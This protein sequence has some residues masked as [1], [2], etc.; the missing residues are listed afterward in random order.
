[1]SSATELDGMFQAGIAA[2]Q[3]GDYAQAVVLLSKLSRCER[4]AYRMQANMGLV[5]A[6]MAQQ[7]WQEAEALCQTIGTSA[8]PA[9]K[10]WS[11]TTLEKIEQRRARPKRL[12]SGFSPLAAPRNSSA[13]AAKPS[14]GF[15][16]LDPAPSDHSDQAQSSLQP[17]AHQ[18]DV[19]SRM[20]NSSGAFV[21][22]AKSTV[23]KSKTSRRR[24][25]SSPEEVADSPDS[26]TEKGPDEGT[27]LSMFHYAYLN[28]ET[29]AAALRGGETDEKTASKAAAGYLWTYAGRLQKGRSL[30]KMK[31]GKLWFAQG[32]S[33][34][35]FYLLL[36]SLIHSSL[37]LLNGY[38]H[39]LDN[40]FP[41][42]VRSLPSS[43][44]DVTW[45]LLFGLGLLT[46]AAPWLWD[47]W[48]LLTADRKPLSAS[49]LRA[50]SAE[51]AAL[52]HGYC[53]QR[54]FSFPTLWTLKTDIPLIFSYGWRPK[55]ARLVI[56]QGLL[57]QLKKDE[58]AALVAY[59]LSHWKGWHW[60]LL[61]AQGLILQVLLEGYWQLSVWGNR[62]PSKL[63][64]YT[65]GGLAMVSYAVF[66][67]LGIPSRW[68]SR[69]R[70][71]YSDRMAAELTGNPNGLTRGLTNL[72]FGLAA[73]VEQ[74]TYTP[75][76]VESLMPLLPAV[77][78][79]ARQPLFGHLPLS[80]LFAWDS[81]QPLRLW[82]S[83]AETHPP[84]GDRLR[85]LMA[86]AKHWR[87]DLEIP[88]LPASRQ[89]QKM[90][91]QD[92]QVLLQQG[93]P[94][95][96]L[97]FGLLIGLGLWGTGLVAIWLQWPALDWMYQDMGLLQCCCLLGTSV[98]I[99][100]RI[101]RF[102]PDLD[103]AMPASQ[104]VPDWVSRPD[105]LPAD[106]LPAKL[107]GV[108]VG[109]PGIANWLGQDLLL[110]TSFGLVKLHYFSLLGPLGNVLS[111]EQTPALVQGKSMQVLG[112]F[113]RGSRPWL[114]VDRL[115]LDNGTLLQAAHP[116]YSLLLAAVTSFWGLWAL[117]QSSGY[118]E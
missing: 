56:S 26:A 12:K 73:S 112:W 95:F 86:Y 25:L 71:Y 4:S 18:S 81:G 43:F 33:A 118:V 96:G 91:Q 110:K 36:R 7:K 42:W 80:Q 31:R 93:T 98:G 15:S 117:V 84:L 111:R 88:L 114:D 58:I 27:G 51:A 108:L 69:L 83:C 32:S 75:P 54:R 78:D 34:I 8:R 66:W 72:A 100:L 68:L 2:Y 30:G 44:S 63:L 40:L 74:R 55:N 3:Q 17:V 76:I 1:M 9:L 28:G 82:L 61:S 35:A 46:L 60:P 65:A 85:V 23:A 113:R 11:Q 79:L 59:E 41:F 87:L 57:S 90:T 107:P 94:F 47:A 109:R 21:T 13:Q 101:N 103:M 77:P 20:P 52:I 67:L 14:S 97:A 64:K 106:S 62:Q 6:Y 24:V 92:R 19:V 5:R 105:I 99:L 50:H 116:F 10:Q 70:T 37:S 89:K 29:D 16:P 48:L 102:F 22:V 38:L 45:P 104:S 49:Q 53:R 115:R 39:F